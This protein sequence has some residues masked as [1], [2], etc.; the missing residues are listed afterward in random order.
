MAQA[1]Q[2]LPSKCEALSSNSQYHQKKNY[3]PLPPPQKRKA[4]SKKRCWIHSCPHGAYFPIKWGSAKWNKLP[5][6]PNSNLRVER[7]D[8]GS[9]LECKLH[10]ESTDLSR[11]SS[12]SPYLACRLEVFLL[13]AINNGK[14]ESYVIL[15]GHTWQAQMALSLTDC[16]TFLMCNEEMLR[17]EATREDTQAWILLLVHEDLLYTRPLEEFSKN[18]PVFS[19]NTNIW[20]L[21]LIL[22]FYQKYIHVH[23]FKKSKALKDWVLVT[24]T[25]NPNYLGG[26]DEEN[27]NLRPAQANTS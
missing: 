16:F 5:E 27:D 23:N 1:V 14:P 3:P 26:W 25:Y 10:L 17:S 9:A 15:S 8:S 13:S 4:L 21:N 22:F 24:H 12:S 18:Y 11:H 7:W 6:E 2:C 19:A 20:L